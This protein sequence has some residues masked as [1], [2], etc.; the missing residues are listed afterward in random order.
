MKI[1]NLKSPLSRSPK[2]IPRP[3]RS[4]TS[5]NEAV[6]PLPGRSDGPVHKAERAGMS[7]RENVKD[8]HRVT[9]TRSR[10][11]PRE[12]RTSS[13]KLAQPQDGAS[14][15]SVRRERRRGRLDLVLV[16]SES[17]AGRDVCTTDCDAPVCADEQNPNVLALTPTRAT[18]TATA[19]TRNTDS[20]AAGLEDQA[21]R[22]EERRA[23]RK[24]TELQ[25][26]AE[27]ARDS[28]D[29]KRK[30]ESNF[31][32]ADSKRLQLQAKRYKK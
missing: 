17:A 24:L 25:M 12:N 9:P 4:P 1:E 18:T 19:S 32:E 21:K 14:S 23:R 7:E 8:V 29:R 31:E 27:L 26:A 2:K 11:T 15:Q 16:G 28:I 20:A 13:P 6:L 22:R 10:E 3:P 30:L 5:P